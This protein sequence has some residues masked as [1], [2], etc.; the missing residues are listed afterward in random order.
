MNSEVFIASSDGTNLR[1]ITNNPAFDGWPAWSPD[2]KWIAFAS[3]R[4]SAYQ[5]Y[6]MDP[7]GGNIR[8]VANTEGRATAPRWS[9]DS[10]TIYFTNCRHS[11]YGYDC[12]VFVAK[13]SEADHQ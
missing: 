9:S 1:N 7:D 6:I 3:N 13:L 8:L 5:I 4:E 12:E 11:D 10:K 2:G